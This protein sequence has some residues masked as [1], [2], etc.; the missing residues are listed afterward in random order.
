MIVAIIDDG[1]DTRYVGKLAFD[2]VAELHGEKAV[3]HERK[4]CNPG[5]T[6]GTLCAVILALYAK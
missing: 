1:L 5:F 6:H 4:E 3:L 2:L